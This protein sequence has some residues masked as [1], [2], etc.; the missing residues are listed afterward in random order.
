MIRGAL[1]DFILYRYTNVLDRSENIVLNF[2]DYF[3]F[4]SG[5]N[6]VDMFF[7]STA[8]FE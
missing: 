3:P 1:F 2:I 8:S 4:V 7:I 6:A 5:H